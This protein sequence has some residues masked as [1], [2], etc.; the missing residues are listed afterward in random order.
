MTENQQPGGAQGPPGDDRRVPS[1]LLNW[2]SLT[3]MGLIALGFAAGLLTLL[4]DITSVQARAYTGVLFLVYLVLIL[5]GLVVIPL[6]LLHLRA[7]L[8]LPSRTDASR[9]SALRT[10]GLLVAGVLAWRATDTVS[11]TRST[12]LTGAPMKAVIPEWE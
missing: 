12:A 3:G 10:G 4:L 5:G 6:L 7:R 1:A 11:S 2:T 9:R 8:E